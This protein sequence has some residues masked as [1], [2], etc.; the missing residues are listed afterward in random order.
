MYAKFKEK[1]NLQLVVAYD[2][3]LFNQFGIESVPHIIIADQEGKVHA[4]T[5]S[6]DLTNEKL[7]ALI[8]HKRVRFNRKYSK[9]EDQSNQYDDA[10]WYYLMD[11]D[12]LENRDFLYRSILSVN[13]GEHSNGA[14]RIDQDVNEG[15]YQATRL[16]LCMLYNVA[17]LG[18][19]DW[20]ISDTLYTTQW[21]YPILEIDDSSL[22][23]Y[24]YTM[25]KGFFNYTLVVPKEKA[26]AD[27]LQAIMRQELKNCFGYQVEAEIR[28]M[29]YWKLVASE[30]S[31]EKLK[32]LGGT[33]NY[34]VD[35]AGVDLTNAPV[36]GL[37]NLICHYHH[38]LEYLPFVN[39][40]GIDENI[41][42]KFDA[43]MT[44]LED[45]RRALRESGLNLEKGWKEMKVL[46]IRNSPN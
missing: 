25:N 40:T 9:Y 39:E 37:L 17:Y 3:S 38:E 19:T 11:K 36:Q 6:S 27:Y 43:I 14:F 29:P 1:Q 41:D 23:Q 32:T 46:V 24:D 20:G 2:T 18:K 35:H 26:N 31:K 8:H 7:E 12:E 5:F 28:M 45:V 4:V 34:V 33:R 15:C 44:D 21:K 16:N 30:S 10:K 13:N 42:I 22:F